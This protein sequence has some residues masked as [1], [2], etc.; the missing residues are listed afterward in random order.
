MAHRPQPLGPVV[1]PGHRHR[2]IGLP[3]PR[4]RTADPL[5]HRR[6]RHEEGLR[7]L[8]VVSPQTARSVSGMAALGDSDGWQ[9]SSSTSS[10]SSRPGTGA[11]GTVDHEAAS[12]SRRRRAPCWRCWSINRRQATRNSHPP[13]WRA[14]PAQASCPPPRPAPPGPRPPR[15][16][17]PLTTGQPPPGPA[18]RTP[19]AA[20]RRAPRSGQPSRSGG[21][22]T[23]RTSMGCRIGAPPGPGAADARAAISTARSAE[24]TSTIRNPA[25][26][27]RDSG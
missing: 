19:A 6:V 26:S 1:W 27:S 5:G 14:R 11:D 3:Q 22:M 13:G 4:L 16:R 17:S 23:W 20:P 8:P 9:H 12:T 21:P 24:S 10:V 2:H 7:D 15:R 18:A 25:S